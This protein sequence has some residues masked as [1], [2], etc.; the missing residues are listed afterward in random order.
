MDP[1]RG[2]SLQEFAA[3]L[4]KANFYELLAVAMVLNFR[5]RYKNRYG[6]KK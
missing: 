5:N 6:G 3:A 2:G 4:N 1:D